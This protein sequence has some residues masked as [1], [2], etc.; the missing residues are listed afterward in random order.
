MRA[1]S[2]VLPALRKVALRAARR[3]MP[4]RF[5]GIGRNAHNRVGTTARMKAGERYD[6]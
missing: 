2:F 1:R 5:S 4:G 3:I 6:G